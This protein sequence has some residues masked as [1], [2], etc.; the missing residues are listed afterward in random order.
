MD[1]EYEIKGQISYYNN[2]ISVCEDDIA[3]LQKQIEQLEELSFELDRLKRS[4]ADSQRTRVLANEKIRGLDYN[5]KLTGEYCKGT[6]S[7]LTGEKYLNAESG[8]TAAKQKTE[9]KI[10]DLRQQLAEQQYQV[11]Y[12]QDIINDLYNQLYQME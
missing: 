6:N 2:Q 1:S 9:Q 7:L 10:A 12:Y 8:L 3:N 4:F 11:N 5:V